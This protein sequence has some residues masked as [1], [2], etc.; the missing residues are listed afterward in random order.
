MSALVDRASER[1][2]AVQLA[3]HYRQ[4]EDLPIAEIARRLGRS[5]ATI[6]AYLY[7]PSGE[8]A[9]A[10]KASY[11]GVCHGC[12]RPT[13]ARGGKNDPYQYC[14]T[15]RPGAAKQHWTRER[16]IN[17]MLAWQQQYGRLP[18]SYDWSTTHATRRGGLALERLQTGEWP[19]AAT[20]SELFG[21]WHAATSS[22][23]RTSRTGG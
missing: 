7:D 23:G 22:S 3:R 10:L 1:R 2:R 18:S 4:Q 20:V 16:V 5:P 19:A 8:K 15:C 17:A 13:A 11:R 6:K 12:G 9:K 21:T 14:H